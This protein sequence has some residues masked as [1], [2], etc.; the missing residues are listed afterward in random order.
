MNYNESKYIG[1]LKHIL[2]SGIEK[3]DRTNTGTLSV[4]GTQTRYDLTESKIPLLTTKYIHLKSVIHELLWF[5]SGSTNIKYL[6]DNGVKIWNEWSDKNGNL[7]PVYG[8]QW[9]NWEHKTTDI[10]EHGSQEVTISINQIEKL[11]FDIK[12]NP[13]SRRHIVSA[14]NVGELNEMALPP[15]HLLSQFFVTEENNKKY[16]SCQVYQ[17][18]A[19][20]FLGVPFNIASYSLLTHMIAQQL[21]MYAKELIHVTGDTHIYL[22][23]IEQVKTQLSREIHKKEPRVIIKQK[24]DNI[25]SY[26]FYDFEFID[27]N[28]QAPIKAPVAI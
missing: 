19:D 7:G 8:K 4:I 5:L 25:F 6:Q 15:C 17:R 12:T 20:M 18:S 23:H 16:L 14:W 3:D 1:L 22:N 26:Q 21:G 24:P 2:H 11:I 13:H 9:T 10:S 28:P 27:Y